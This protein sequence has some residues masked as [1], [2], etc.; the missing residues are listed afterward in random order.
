MIFW[1]V[2][3]MKR[4]KKRKDELNQL[5]DE[6]EKEK[7]LVNN[8]N[9]FVPKVKN[10]LDAFSITDNAEKKNYLLKSV[11]DKASYL[12]KKEWKKKDE[13]VI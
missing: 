8:I 4:L 7:H 3:I 13:F 1:N 5:N 10:V 11:L 12:R 6:I 2:A 9:E